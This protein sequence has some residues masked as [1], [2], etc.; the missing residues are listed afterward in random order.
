VARTPRYFTHY[1]DEK[2]C[3]S[4]E[5]DASGKPFRHT[6]SNQLRE[7]GVEP[8]DFVYGWS[9]SGGKLFL[10]GRMQVDRFVSQREADALYKDMGWVAWEANDHVI[11]QS[12]AAT[13]MH[14]NRVV[15]PRLISQLT[16][17]GPTGKVT[18]AKFFAK[19]RVNPQTFRGVRE[20]TRGAAQ[21]LDE[22][23]DGGSVRRDAP[24]DVIVESDVD[25]AH[26]KRG[27]GSGQRPYAGITDEIRDFV[28]SKRL[29]A[30]GFKTNPAI[31]NTV[32]QYAVEQARDHYENHGFRV[33]EHGRPFDLK[34]EN[35]GNV[36]YV[37]VKGTQTSGGEVILTPNE[38]DFAQ[39]NQMELFVLHSVQVTLRKNRCIARGGVVRVV[40]PWRPQRAQLQP[41]AFTC[42]I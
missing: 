31:R 32:E 42:S 16:F 14:F 12:G 28:E 33:H 21:L 41:I 29:T 3:R 15:P 8:G 4:Q 2:T 39:K 7:R 26:Q 23:I 18:P 19:G 37:E 38:V 30:Q 24:A 13:P 40:S 10:L 35:G 25:A 5:E 11:A 17:Q 27:N 9:F 6:A 1:W 34:C 36:L 22:L 20:L